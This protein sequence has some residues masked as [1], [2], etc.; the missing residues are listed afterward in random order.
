VQPECRLRAFG[1]FALGKLYDA[2]REIDV[3][4]TQ[5]GDILESSPAAV[6]KKNRTAPVSRGFLLV[7]VVAGLKQPRDLFRRKAAF[8]TRL[9]LERLK[10]IDRVKRDLA[11]LSRE[12]KRRIQ[13]F[14]DQ[15]VDGRGRTLLAR[16]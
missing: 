3:A 12:L 13:I 2:V 5:V 16:Y 4:P 15:L 9:D 14:L 10:E 11:R 6:G 8:D 1:T 7:E